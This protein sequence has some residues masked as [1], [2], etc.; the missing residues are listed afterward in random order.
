MAARPHISPALQQLRGWVTIAATVVILA[1]L[2]QVA[3]YAIVRNTDVRATQLEGTPNDTVVDDL[4]RGIPGARQAVDTPGRKSLAP[5][6]AHPLATPG[7]AAV[8]ASNHASAIDPNR[9]RSTTDANL[10]VA[11]AFTTAVGLIASGAL[12]ILALLGIVVAGGGNVPGIAYTVRAGVWSI[13]IL[14]MALPWSGFAGPTLVPGVFAG[15]GTLVAAAEG[16]TGAAVFTSFGMMP[17]VLVALS[18]CCLYWFRRGVEAGIVLTSL[19][20]VDEALEREMGTIRERGVGRLNPGGRASA[21]LHQVIEPDRVAV[22][23]PRRL[24]MAAGAERLRDDVDDVAPSM[25]RRRT[26]PG[27]ARPI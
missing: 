26:D 9:I 15:Y 1:A 3:A 4:R 23:E 13:V 14:G 12:C 19:S 17:I 2:C 8:A 27:G 20:E 5:A 7:S 11:C 18:G 22:D 10:K 25:L 16:R 24:R 6:P 21:G